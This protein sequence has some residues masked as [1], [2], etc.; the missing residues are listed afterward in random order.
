MR[1]GKGNE[2]F[3]FP[4]RPIRSVY[5]ARSPLIIIMSLLA[6]PHPRRDPTRLSFLQKPEVSSQVGRWLEGVMLL[7]FLQT[8]GFTMYTLENVLTVA[9]RERY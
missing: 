6:S 8:I 5:S 4:E 1:M 9:E 3:D 7:S 2:I